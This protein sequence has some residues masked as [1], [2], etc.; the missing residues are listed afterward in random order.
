M[1]RAPKVA[2]VHDLSGYGRCSL[3][4]ILPVLAAMGDQCCPLTTAY[5]SAHTAFPATDRAVFL[6]LTDSMALVA[7][8]WAELDVSFDAVYS[9]FLGSAKQIKLLRDFI[10]RFRRPGTLVLVD[11]V[12]GDHGRPYRTYPPEMCA[13]MGLLAADADLITPNLTEAALLLGEEYRPQPDRA[14]VRAWL[15]R[16][17][18]GGKR[19]VVITGVSDGPGHIGAASLSRENG[20]MSM[21]MAREEAGSFPGTGD[22]FAAVLLGSLLQGTA[23]DESCERAVDFVQK[24]VQRTLALETEPLEGV[25]FEGLLG[26]LTSPATHSASGR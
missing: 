23:L 10:V 21:S 16:L 2:A 7:G 6:D 14:T 17:S 18:L 3:T 24:C 25:Q 12:M 22:L 8:H 26:Y 5:L 9:G 11:P 1:K 4:V 13:Q 19:S 20:R 15:E